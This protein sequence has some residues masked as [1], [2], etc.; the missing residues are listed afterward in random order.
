[1]KVAVL[2]RYREPLIIE[3]LEV[4]KPRR[5][6]VRVRP[7]ASGICHSDLY[8]LDGATPIPPPLVPGHESIQA[9]YG[10]VASA[11]TALQAVRTSVRDLPWPEL[12]VPY[13]MGQRVSKGWMEPQS[14]YSSEA[15]GLR[16]RWCLP[17][18]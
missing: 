6:E 9:L 7:I 5:G 17:R 4:E 2:N 8:V 1:M 18:V 16:R 3:D 12:G 13:S 14:G 15:S 10:P 11:G